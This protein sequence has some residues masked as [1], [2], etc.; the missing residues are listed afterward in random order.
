MTLLSG[1]DGEVHFQHT[2]TGVEQICVDDSFTVI[3]LG[4]DHPP[5]AKTVAGKLPVTI[6]GSPHLAISRDGRYGFVANHGWRGAGILKGNPQP[7]PVEHRPNVLSV[8]DLAA[9]NLRVVDHVSLPSG[10]WMLDLHP[11]GQKVIV[12]VGAGFQIYAVQADRL[13]QVAAATAPST[14]FSF[15]VS[16]RCETSGRA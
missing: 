14:V 3:H 5:I 1:N 4:P 9:D 10:A 16:P 6:H 2:A 13:V 7:V 15:D 11:D 8:I 12:G